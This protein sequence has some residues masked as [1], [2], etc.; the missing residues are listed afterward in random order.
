LIPRMTLA[1][2]T[3]A[4]SVARS[5]VSADWKPAPRR[6]ARRGR[7]RPCAPGSTR[8]PSL[9]SMDHDLRKSIDTVVCGVTW[10]RMVSRTCTGPIHRHSSDRR[11]SRHSEGRYEDRTSVPPDQYA[12]ASCRRGE[13]RY[14]R[15]AE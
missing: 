13:G 6:C 9:W 14:R 8:G 5:N 3:T 11:A 4:T 7:G 15:T 10:P 1:N 12:S 2:A